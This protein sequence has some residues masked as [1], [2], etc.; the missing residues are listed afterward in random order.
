[1]AKKLCKRWFIDGLGAM[2]QGLFASLIIGVIIQKLADISFLSWLLPFSEIVSAKSPVVGAAIGVA[3]A[4][5]FK[6]SPLTIFSCAAVGAFGYQVGGPVGAYVATL[7]GA[8]IGGLVAG[9]TKLDILLVPFSA[10]V[11]GCLVG[12]FVGPS[13]STFMT[14]LGSFINVAAHMHPLPSGIIISLV[15][16]MVLTA[17]ISSAAL[18][19]SLGLEGIAAGAAT[20]GCCVNMLGFAIMS[21]RANGIGGFFAQGIGTS[22]LQVPNIVKKP[23]IWLPVMISSAILGPIGTTLLPMY[24]NP[25][26]AGM[27]T[28]GIVGPINA[29]IT[30]TQVGGS[31]IEVITKILVMLVI[32]PLVVTYAIYLPFRKSGIIKDSD[33]KLNI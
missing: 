3:I 11:S 9:K 17:P 28:S 10:I 24:N 25:Y 30:M 8:E 18:C 23:V 1:M 14:W 12:Q 32:L 26:G 2:A 21:Y 4:S 20:I 19:I 31:P 29:Y 5:S 15:V 6:V 7:V 22:M 16:G 33:L 13:I 27:G